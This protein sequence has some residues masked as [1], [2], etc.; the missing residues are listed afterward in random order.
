MK[1]LA[2]RP[3]PKP[4]TPARKEQTAENVVPVRRIWRPNYRVRLS[5]EWADLARRQQI[6]NSPGR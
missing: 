5:C 6:E 1:S 3:S 4:L 2:E